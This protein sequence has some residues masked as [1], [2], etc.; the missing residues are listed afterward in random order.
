MTEFGNQDV[1]TLQ[2][3]RHVN[4]ANMSPNCEACLKGYLHVNSLQVRQFTQTGKLPGVCKVCNSA[5]LRICR[6]QIRHLTQQE[7]PAHVCEI[8]SKSFTHAGNYRKHKLLHEQNASPKPENNEGDST[9]SN[10]KN[11][12]KPPFVCEKCGKN[13]LKQG[14]F[15]KHCAAH[16][17][18][19]AFVCNFCDKRFNSR[20]YLNVHIRTHL[21]SQWHHCKICKEG[22]SSI[23]GLNQHMSLLHA[24]IQSKSESSP[25]CTVKEEVTSQTQSS[26]VS[27]SGSSE[28]TFV[29]ECGAVEEA[30]EQDDKFNH[31]CT[32]CHKGF[33]HMG[34]MKNH[35]LTHSGELPYQCKTSGLGVAFVP[36]V[37]CPQKS[38]LG[39]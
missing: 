6:L 27:Q 24:G 29:D 2:I 10:V 28:P 26:S 39:T 38:E 14:C 15:Q 3:R 21:R 18:V 13:F 4:A 25:N 32:L 17:A 23:D 9:A 19:A 31:F 7:N 20:S 11:G 34:A 36:E 1:Y 12:P 33:V 35:L 22:F 37:F 5:F 8:C 16:D 30:I